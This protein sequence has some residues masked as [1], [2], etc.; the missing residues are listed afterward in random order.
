MSLVEMFQPIIAE[1]EL[2]NQTCGKRLS[3]Y[4]TPVGDFDEY[5][6]V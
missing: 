5:V 6:I 2:L 1:L 4:R 3:T